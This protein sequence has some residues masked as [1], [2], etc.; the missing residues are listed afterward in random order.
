[1]MDMTSS[2]GCSLDTRRDGSASSGA[3]IVDGSEHLKGGP[4]LLLRLLDVATGPALLVL[5]VGMCGK[6]GVGRFD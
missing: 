3:S 1:M 5:A 4:F 2:E 6:G